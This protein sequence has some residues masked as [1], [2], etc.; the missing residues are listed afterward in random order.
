VDGRRQSTAVAY[1]EPARGRP[2]L[3]ILADTTAVRVR[4]DGRTACGV[5]IAGSDGTR[6]TIHADEVVVA[7]GVF[8]SPGLL[9]RSGIGS[10]EELERHG[11]PVVAAL[12]GVGQGF[13]D[14]AVVYIAFAPGPALRDGG[15]IPKVRLIL[16]SD[17]DRP[18][19][20]LHVLL[21][22]P[23]RSNG[24]VHVPVSVRLLEH[25]SVGRVR[26][27]STDPAALPVVEPALL[28]HPDDVMALVRGIG[29]VER[30]VAHPAMAPFY[31]PRI[32]PTPT[33]DTAGYVRST[34]ISYHHGVGTCRFGPAN[35]A[36][37][38]VDPTL[39]VRG[40][41]GLWVADASVLPTV[42]HAN[43]NLA[44]ILVG[45]LAARRVAAG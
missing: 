44:A 13:Q 37:A 41:D 6:R 26:L 22:P 18:A 17:P 11:I 24:A 30:L 28:D 7:A 20:D 8:H 12:E 2:N 4:T 33:E 14:H 35:D 19:P 9:L 29:E 27:A 39:R 36:A 21:H 31:G 15:S 25:R 23:V 3:T 1:L 38:V 34:Y 42:P 43:T 10:P 32:R 5:E 45:E 40:V 16:R